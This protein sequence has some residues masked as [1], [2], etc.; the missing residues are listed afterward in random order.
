VHIS[1]TFI[2]NPPRFV[3]V[4]HT[5]Y[6]TARKGYIFFPPRRSSR[7]IK[8][9]L[10][11]SRIS[12]FTSDAV[13]SAY[14]VVGIH[15]DCNMLGRLCK[16][17]KYV[18]R[19]RSPEENRKS[20]TGALGRVKCA[21]FEGNDEV[22]ALLVYNTHGIRN[23]KT[24]ATT[25]IQYTIIITYI[26]QYNYI[27]VRCCLYIYIYIGRYSTTLTHAH[28]VLIALITPHPEPPN[29][30]HNG[31]YYNNTHHTSNRYRN[32]IAICIYGQS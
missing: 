5:D 18:H 13:S 4:D 6:D 23:N 1:V 9:A 8:S 26:V 19:P 30:C 20:A 28:T 21:F 11:A 16:P 24:S 32:R 31:Q 22:T 29:N 2:P 10:N 14:I 25:H 7:L 27:P 3:F 12:S 17:V 15:S